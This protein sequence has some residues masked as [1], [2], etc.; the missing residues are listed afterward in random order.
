MK[1]RSE[2]R[3]RM[4]AGSGSRETCLLSPLTQES[5]CRPQIPRYRVTPRFTQTRKVAA[6]DDPMVTQM[7]I[8]PLGSRFIG[9]R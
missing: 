1:S 6:Q 4:G 3:Q 7:G 2:A 8:D 9:D 5:G